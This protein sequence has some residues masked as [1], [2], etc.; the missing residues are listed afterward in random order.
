MKEHKTNKA[1]PKE[2]SSYET[3]IYFRKIWKI[4]ANNKNR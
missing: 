2:T 3:I 1:E 4:V